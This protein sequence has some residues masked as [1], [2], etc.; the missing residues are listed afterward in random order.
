MRGLCLGSVLFRSALCL[1][2]GFDHSSS[3]T[4]CDV[5]WRGGSGFVLLEI[6]PV[7]KG[8]WWLH[9]RWSLFVL[10]LWRTW[11]NFSGLH[12]IYSLLW[13]VWTF[14]QC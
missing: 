10:F 14:Q 12:W 4:P 8:L 7:L 9:T 3:A 13:G 2:A 1:S 6:A 11:W 5:R